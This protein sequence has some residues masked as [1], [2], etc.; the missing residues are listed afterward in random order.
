LPA[1][2]FPPL[3]FFAIVSYPP[4]QLGSFRGRSRGPRRLPPGTRDRFRRSQAEVWHRPNVWADVDRLI[5]D[6]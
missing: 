5:P 1:F 2:F 3:A 6:V 4:L